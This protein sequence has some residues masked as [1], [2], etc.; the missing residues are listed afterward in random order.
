ML[1][2]GTICRIP[3]KIVKQKLKSKTEEKVNV[4]KEKKIW[5]HSRQC[6]IF[7]SQG[8]DKAEDEKIFEK[9]ILLFTPLRIKSKIYHLCSTPA[10]I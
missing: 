4:I 7:N 9:Q 10:K 1:H 2:S 6:I 8:F 5:N 3:K